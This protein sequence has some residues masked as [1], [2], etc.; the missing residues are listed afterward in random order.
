MRGRTWNGF[1][2]LTVA[3]LGLGACGGD[4]AGDGM[5]DGTAAETGA[6]QAEPAAQE[7]VTLA[8]GVTQEQFDM[9]QQLFTG[10]G[11]CQA[12]HGPQALGTQLAPNLKDDEWINISDPTVE[13]IAELIRTGVQQPVEHPAPMPPFGGANLNEEQVQALAAYVASIGGTQG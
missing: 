5:Q 1:A 11:G 4:G 7:P 2:L 3:A 10:Q 6:P 13:Q 9:G 8:E 12:C